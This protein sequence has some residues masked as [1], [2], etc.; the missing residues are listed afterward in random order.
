MDV[1]YQDYMIM[2][3]VSNSSAM[4]C[5]VKTSCALSQFF[6]GPTFLVPGYFPQRN[7]VIKNKWL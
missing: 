5:S 2:L 3:R 4:I 6:A 7:C 1:D